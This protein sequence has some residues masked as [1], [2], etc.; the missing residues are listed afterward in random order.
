[1]SNI[2][3]QR[4]AAVRK[5]EQLGYRFADDWH[6]PTG[7]TAATPASAQADG[8]H[9]LLVQ[10]ADAL[11]ECTEGSEEERELAA[12]TDAIEAYETLRLAKRQGRWGQGVGAVRLL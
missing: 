1:M 7:V 8:M 5:L 6:Q 11:E 10:R 3:K 9:A 2:D 12:I 4:V